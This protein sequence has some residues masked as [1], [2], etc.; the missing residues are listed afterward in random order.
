MFRRSGVALKTSLHWR[1]EWIELRAEFTADGLVE[2]LLIFV[3][4]TQFVGVLLSSEARR[5]G[6]RCIVLIDFHHPLLSRP[7]QETHFLLSCVH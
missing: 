7:A 5:G 2:Q 6:L 1:S 3:K 4:Y